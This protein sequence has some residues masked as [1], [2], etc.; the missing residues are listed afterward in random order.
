MAVAGPER[1][2]E[3]VEAICLG[4]PCQEKLVAV[5]VDAVLLMAG[6]VVS[7]VRERWWKGDSDRSSGMEG[8]ALGIGKP[9]KR[10]G[11]R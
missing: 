10:K 6:G 2:R 11:F 3:S 8:L 4:Q 5:A 9:S 1:Y 7:N